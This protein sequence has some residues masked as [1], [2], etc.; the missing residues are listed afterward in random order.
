M[1]TG[2]R[3][4]EIL[5]GAALMAWAVAGMGSN[6][7]A[8]PLPQV[9]GPAGAA[10]AG[11]RDADTTACDGSGWRVLLEEG[12][13]AGQLDPGLWLPTVAHD[14]RALTREVVRAPGGDDLELWLGA[15]TRD[16]DDATVKSVGVVYVHPLPLLPAVEIQV[17]LDWNDQ[18]NGSYLSAGLFLERG[19]EP[20]A[21]VSEGPMRSTPDDAPDWL[22]LEYV[23]VPP[24]H[25]AR[26][27]VAVRQAG[28]V[29]F[30]H[31]EGWPDIRPEGRP[32]HRQRLR[33]VLD[34]GRVGV[35]ENGRPLLEPGEPVF[36]YPTAYL[37]LRLRSHSNYPHRAVVF[38]DVRVRQ[39]C[40]GDEESNR[41]P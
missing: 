39:R 4:A 16:T 7:L 27:T 24:G 12:F 34:R 38:D 9:I 29:R 14:L 21:R 13:E 8:S 33:L 1:G 26:A 28:R 15:D 37:H 31:T 17:E 41:D 5:A 36:R 10:A 32:V 40:R 20:E 30:L 6:V 19:P 3:P 2:R 18:A 22:A 25:N 23:G 35:E 11:A